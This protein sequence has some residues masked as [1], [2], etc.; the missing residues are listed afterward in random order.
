[1]RDA[2]PLRLYGDTS[3]LALAGKGRFVRGLLASGVVE[4]LVHGSDLPVPIQTAPMVWERCIGLAAWWRISRIRNALARDIALKRTLGR[5]PSRGS[6]SSGGVPPERGWTPCAAVWAVAEKSGLF[7][8]GIGYG[9][10][11]CKRSLG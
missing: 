1:L 4:R 3:A 9:E 5:A 6:S 11:A 8:A 10:A 7:S 2:G